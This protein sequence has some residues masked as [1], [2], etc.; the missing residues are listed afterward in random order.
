M[1]YIGGR[2]ISIANLRMIGCYVY[3]HPPGRKPSKL[4]DHVNRGRFLGY[5]AIWNHIYYLDLLTKKVEMTIH[6]RFDEDMSDLDPPRT[7]GNLCLIWVNLSNL[8]IMKPL[9]ILNV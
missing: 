4:E 3:A 8:S 1:V 9:S 7:Q 6:A 5:T 2:P